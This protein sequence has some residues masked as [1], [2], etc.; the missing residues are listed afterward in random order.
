MHRVGQANASMSTLWIRSLLL[1]LTPIL[2]T[3]KAP[4]Q[5]VSWAYQG[6]GTN[7]DGVY[8]AA[9]DGA[10][11]YIVCGE[12]QGGFGIP[13]FGNYDAFVTRLNAAG[14]VV[15][16]RLIG[17]NQYESASAVTV[18]SAGDVFV[19]GTTYGNLGGVSNGNE[20]MWVA[21]LDLAGTSHWTRQFGAAGSDYLFACIAAANG[22]VVS[23]GMT[24]SSLYAASAGSNDAVVVRLNRSGSVIWGRQFG[25]SGLD[26][27]LCVAEATGGSFWVGGATTGQLGASATGGQDAWLAQLSSSGATLGLS[28][29]GSI[30]NDLTRGI[31]ADSVG[32][33]YACGS[34]E[35]AV[36]GTHAGYSDAWIARFDADSDLQWSRQLG[37]PV[38][39]FAFDLTPDG[40]GGV[41]ACGF[42]RGTLAAAS[43]GGADAWA[44]RYRADGVQLFI[45]QFG[46]PQEDY[47]FACAYNLQGDHAVAGY[48]HGS[49]GGPQAG[50]G[51]AWA[52]QIDCVYDCFVDADGDG[53]GAGP[54]SIATAPCGAGWALNADDCDDTASSV[55]PGAPELCDGLDNDC[56][57]VIDD[58][59][60]STY[61]T[62]GTS[63]HG[64]VASI[65]G[66][67]TPSTTAGSGFNVVVSNVPGQRYGTIFYGFYPANVP[68]APNSPSYRCVSF[69]IQRMGNL[70]THGTTSQCNGDLTID[71]NAWYAANPG[72]LGAP[73]IAGQVF[74]AQGWYRD[75]AAPKQTNLSN[76]LRFTLCN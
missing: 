4:A 14:S 40:A 35:G 64:C 2:A 74:Y 15:W 39:D 18:S 33:V 36:F 48:T 72:A 10:G 53:F 24:S 27:A 55:Y 43:L 65:A 9:P 57:G 46:T 70:P 44:A 63:V 73:F 6:G 60:I 58:G 20:D 59:F 1:V 38:E 23:V 16:T 26:E 31:A 19:V 12:T 30:G 50:L 25:S 17:T 69:P 37:S 34:T 67:G 47:T 76:G 49:I 13:G 41:L 45:T 75:P 52:A 21:M 5:N 22:D 51:D 28:Q 7:F 71:F 29:F 3:T 62:A 56:D 61:C 32:G 54:G 68:W 8:G 42:T 66:V 11:G